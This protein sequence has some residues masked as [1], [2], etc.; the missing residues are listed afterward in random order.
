MKAGTEAETMDGC[1]LL[2]QLTLW[3]SQFVYTAQAHLPRNGTIHSACS[4]QHQLTV[5]TMATGQS[6]GDNASVEVPLPQ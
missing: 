6:V 1:C 2:T 3:L 5:E 4:L